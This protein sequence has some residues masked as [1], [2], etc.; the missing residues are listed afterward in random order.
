MIVSRVLFHVGLG[1]TYNHPDQ[2]AVFI[3][4]TFPDISLHWKAT[5]QKLFSVPLSKKKQKLFGRQSEG[6]RDLLVY[7]K[8]RTFINFSVTMSIKEAKTQETHL[9]LFTE[10]AANSTDKKYSQNKRSSY[11]NRTESIKHSSKDLH[12]P[13]IMITSTS[14]ELS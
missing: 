13:L 2:C 1:S 12:E 14:T 11:A 3:G 9:E 4:N 7:L 6:N 8:L 10:Y 5:N